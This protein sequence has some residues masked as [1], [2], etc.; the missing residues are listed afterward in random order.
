MVAAGS[1]ALSVPRGAFVSLHHNGELLG[2]VGNCGGHMPL[3]EEIGDLTLAAALDDPRFRPATGQRGA[4]DIKISVLTPF[5]RIRDVAE[6]RLGKH[7]AKPHLGDRAGCSAASGSC[8][9][10]DGGG[11]LARPG[12]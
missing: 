4:I 12:A 10:V 7:G 8:A 1:A 11:F 6:F 9:R 3:R 5:R 2:C